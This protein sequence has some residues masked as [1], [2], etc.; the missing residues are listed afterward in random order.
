SVGGFVHDAKN[1]PVARV[2]VRCWGSENP[3]MGGPIESVKPREYSIATFNAATNTFTDTNG[4]WVQD[5]FPGDVTLIWVELT[6]PG[7][8]RNQFV[9]AARSMG[10]Y[11]MQAGEVDLA[12][13]QSARAVFTLKEGTLIQGLVVDEGGKPLAGAVVRERGTMISDTAPYQV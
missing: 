8:A 2:R 3:Y 10:Y 9:T 12:A 7:G 4:F 13:L 11:G 6:Q 1:Q 5:H